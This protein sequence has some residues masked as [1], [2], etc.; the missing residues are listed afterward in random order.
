[1]KPFTLLIVFVFMFSCKDSQKPSYS[2]KKKVSSTIKE[3]EHPGKKLM[4]TNCYV[5][6]SPSTTTGNRI[7]PP[8]IA[9]KNHYISEN[10][11]KEQFVKSIQDWIKNPAKEKAKMFGAVK[12]FG[13]MPKQVFPEKVIKEISE[14]MFDNKIE[15]PKGVEDHFNKNNQNPQEANNKESYSERGLN[16]ALTTKT[17]LGKN[18]MGKIQKEGTLAALKFC[19]VKAYPLTDSMSVV[20]NANIKRVS[21]KPRNIKNLANA[22]EQEYI[23]IFKEDVKSK[24]ESEPIVVTSAENVK[25]YYPIKTNS[26]CLQCHGKPTSDIKAETFAEIK[27]MYPKDLATGYKENQVRGI[28]SITFNK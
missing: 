16:Y 26:M 2:K 24:K 14:Y 28:W 13:V 7:A 18:L 3:Q 8:M 4:K 9:V 20:H 22:K 19:N 27:K 6:H 1:M 25:F 23:A 15:T 12:R 11:T 21:D 5:C 10:T 17:V